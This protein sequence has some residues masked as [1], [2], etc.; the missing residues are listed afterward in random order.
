MKI[1]VSHG[2]LETALR[3]PVG[4]PRGG[5]VLCHPHPVKGGTMHT[6]AI[7]RAGRALNEVGLRTL[8]FNFRG[9][10]CSTGTYDDGIGEEEDVRAALDWLE[11]GLRDR[12]LIVGGLSFGSMVGLSVGMEDPRVVAMVAMG[13]P[14]HVYDH[15]Y[16]ARTQKPVLVIQGEHDEFGSARE[17]GDMLGRLGD[18]VT[19]LGV[20]G[21]GH[22]F[23]GYLEE[24]Q[25]LIREYFTQG[26]G[27][28]AL[29]GGSEKTGGKPA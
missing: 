7:Y 4:T 26:A 11:L 25:E 6:K 29:G 21:A 5:A 16:L 8:R 20:P 27:A 28:G 24:L 2:H 10:G 1:P 17:A 14:I 9:V 13:T 12:P 19:V 22:L 15:S 18:H 23:E 3:N